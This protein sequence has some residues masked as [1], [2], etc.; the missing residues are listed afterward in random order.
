MRLTRRPCV[1][2]MSPDAPGLRLGLVRGGFHSTKHLGPCGEPSTPTSL[3]SCTPASQPASLSSMSRT[4]VLLLHKKRLPA[5]WSGAHISSVASRVLMAAEVIRKVGL[6]LL[7]DKQCIAAG[8]AV[9]EACSAVS[10]M[11]CS[12]GDGG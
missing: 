4:S 8:S 1:W 3:T 6:G 7:L 12:V 9:D 10:C 11:A 2:D 5:S